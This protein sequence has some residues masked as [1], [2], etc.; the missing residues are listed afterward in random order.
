MIQIARFSFLWGGSFQLFHWCKRKEGPFLTPGK[1]VLGI[2][3][4]KPC[5][6]GLL[7]GRELGERYLSCISGQL[8]WT[9]PLFP[10]LCSAMPLISSPPPQRVC[11]G[12]RIMPTV[13]HT[14]SVQCIYK[15]SLV[16]VHNASILEYSRL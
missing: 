16:V 3:Q 2:M 15:P 10:S 9:Q 7:R 6:V 11:G 12:P 1:A 8:S 4:K 13:I 5:G 14:A